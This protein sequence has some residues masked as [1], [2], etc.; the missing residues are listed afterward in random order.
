MM[1]QGQAA[2]LIQKTV[3]GGGYRLKRHRD[4]VALEQVLNREFVVGLGHILPN[5]KHAH[6]LTP[7]NDVTADKIHKP[8]THTLPVTRQLT[9]VITCRPGKQRI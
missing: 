6:Q 2:I 9:A 4:A 7:A 5:K 1:G 3:R 8:Y